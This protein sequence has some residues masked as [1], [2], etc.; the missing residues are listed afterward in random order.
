M[1]RPEA[2]AG[3]KRPVQP[4][5]R[6]DML[7]EVGTY[8]AEAAK[9]LKNPR[10]DCYLTLHGLPFELREVY[11]AV[12]WIELGGGYVPGAWRG[13][14]GDWRGESRCMRRWRRLMTVTFA[15]IVKAP[16][17][18]FAEGIYL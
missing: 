16:E 17:Q 10:Q 7:A 9:R 4:Q 18:P 11:M 3:A 5:Y 6:A 15:E 12:P 2:G 14:A 13:A 1:G 8:L